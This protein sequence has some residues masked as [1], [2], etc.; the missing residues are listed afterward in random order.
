VNTTTNTTP[1]TNTAPVTTQPRAAH[2]L[3][4]HGTN[5][6]DH[7]V[8]T[9]LQALETA[10]AALATGLFAPDGVVHSPLYGDLPARDFYPALFADTSAS[11]LRLRRILRSAQDGGGEE[12]IAFWFDFDWTLADGTPAPFTVVDVAEL[13]GAGLIKHLH[14]VYDTHPL[15]ASWQKQRVLQKPIG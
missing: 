3:P 13:D 14:I 5:S 4:P 12:T 8:S 6:I 11:I 7:L 15:H 9:Y 1:V 2:L 10:D